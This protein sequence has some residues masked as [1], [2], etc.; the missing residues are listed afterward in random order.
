MA[1]SSKSRKDS[2]TND[3]L[4]R[5]LQLIEEREKGLLPRFCKNTGIDANALY[6]CL[7]RGSTPKVDTL[8]RIRNAYNVSLDW[9]VCGI[10]E[11]TGCAAA[12]IS[13][14][15]VKHGQTNVSLST[16]VNEPAAYS[17]TDKIADLE[18][19]IADLKNE[20][21]DWKAMAMIVK[22]PADIEKMN[23]KFFT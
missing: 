3:I 8:V 10:G 19:R 15:G 16:N 23:R 1:H 13:A 5:I 21:D 7:E 18:E 4:L 22:N 9:L 14:T 2:V 12:A 6:R 11:V 17:L 20:R